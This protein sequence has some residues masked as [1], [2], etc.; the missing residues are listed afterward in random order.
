MTIGLENTVYS[1]AEDGGEVE[2]C[3][4]VI[5]S[6]E[7]EVDVTLATEDDTATG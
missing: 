5:S 7:R 6:L 4:S 2:V 1:V 3:V